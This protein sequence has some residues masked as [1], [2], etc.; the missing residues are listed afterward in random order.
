[1]CVGGHAG[2]HADGSLSPAEPGV[3]ML[4]KIIHEMGCDISQPARGT[5]HSGCLG[6]K[7]GMGQLPKKLL[8]PWLFLG[9]L[10]ISPNSSSPAL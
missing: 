6:V 10:Q 5:F 4:I 9:S 2:G 1:M 8:P 3:L 7:K